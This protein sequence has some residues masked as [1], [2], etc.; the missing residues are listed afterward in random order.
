MNEFRYV[1]SIGS[2]SGDTTPMD[3]WLDNAGISRQTN[4]DESD[5]VMFRLI[6]FEFSYATVEFEPNPISSP[7]E[8]GAS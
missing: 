6:G 4:I 1:K 5:L 3:N 8:S 2:Y 7:A